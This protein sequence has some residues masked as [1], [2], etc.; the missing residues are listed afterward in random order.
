MGR[1]ISHARAMAQVCD[2]LDA[3]AAFAKIPPLA[4]IAVRE[5]S[6]EINRKAWIKGVPPG[7]RETVIDCSRNHQFSENDIKSIKQSLIVLKEYGNRAAWAKVNETI[8]SKELLKAF[9]ESNRIIELDAINDL[10]IGSDT[11]EKQ[12]RTATSYQ[13]DWR[14]RKRVQ[15]NA[16]GKCELCG[17]RGFSRSDGSIYLETH[18]IIA[19]AQ[20]GA[21]RISNVIAL[22]AD[23][24]REAHFGASKDELEKTMI[25][26]V[27]DPVGWRHN[28]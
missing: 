6:G 25:T 3:A 8:P 15:D 21:D 12:T 9:K 2:L 1:P 7:T 28:L 19:L 11:P 20:D 24:H 27:T 17:K 23:H 18:H 13:R 22:C 16:A 14:V 26:H 4:L 10:Y 5:I